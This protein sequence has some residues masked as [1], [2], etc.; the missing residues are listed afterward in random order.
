MRDFISP[1]LA[2]SEVKLSTS[3]PRL[4]HTLSANQRTRASD[5]SSGPVSTGD[6]SSSSD[7]V[8]VNS[9]SWTGVATSNGD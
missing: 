5:A 2:T 1:S 9:G 3:H 4:A 8:A 7:I 6:S